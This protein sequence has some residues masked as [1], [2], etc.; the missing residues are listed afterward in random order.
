MRKGT[1]KGPLTGFGRKDRLDEELSS[2]PKLRL[3]GDHVSGRV[4]RP[5]LWKDIER[6]QAMEHLGYHSR[7]TTMG[8]V[9]V[10]ED[11]KRSEILKVFSR[12]SG[13]AAT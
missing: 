11:Q 1:T 6:Q 7:T 5:V 8:Y 4:F 10:N 2:L 13:V 3:L 12:G 9:H